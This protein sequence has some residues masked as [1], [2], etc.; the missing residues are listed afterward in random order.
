MQNYNELALTLATHSA[1]N[2]LYFYHTSC[3]YNT[4]KVANV[5][6]IHR[7]MHA[8]KYNRAIRN[9]E[10]LL[11]TRSGYVAKANAK[12]NWFFLFLTSLLKTKNEKLI[13]F[14]FANLKTKKERYIHGPRT[15]IT[16]V[17]LAYE[18]TTCLFH[19]P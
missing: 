17:V 5:N 18:A 7:N 12:T 9:Y 1:I 13:R 15:I 16:G 11:A 8:S 14:S 3:T 4:R 19:A 2:V 6:K 10:L